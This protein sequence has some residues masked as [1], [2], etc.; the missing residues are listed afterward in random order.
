MLTGYLA[1]W[2]TGYAQ[3]SVTIPA[4]E[5]VVSE[6]GTISIDVGDLSGQNVTS[7]QF[8]IAY[9]SSLINFSGADNAGT[10]T[11]G[12]APIVNTSTPGE[13]TV[14]WA[15]ATPLSGSGTLVKLEAD[16]LQAGNA[17]L[18][19]QSFV[20]NEGT[21]ASST[22]NGTVTITTGGTPSVG[23]R[24]PASS[25]GELGGGAV[26][27]PITVGN[28]GGLNV[29]SYSFTVAYNQAVVGISNT[30]ANG[31]L[32][33]GGTIN[34]NTNQAGQITV[35]WSGGALSG[36]GTLIN[37]IVD[38]LAVGSSQLTFNEFQFNSG[39]PAANLTN[40]SFSVTANGGSVSV[41]ISQSLVG[42]V[43][44]SYMIPI[45]VGETTGK[46]VASFEMELDY[47]SSILRVDGIDQAGTLS[48]NTAAN[49]N[50][51]TPGKVTIAWA[52]TTNLSG[53]GTLINLQVTLLSLGTS[54]LAFSA[55]QFNEGA[56]P[57]VASDG[58]ITVRS[59]ATY[60]Q[61]VHNSS[62]AE[63]VDI[64][65]NDEKQIDALA[66]GVATAFLELDE[67]NLKL[68]V[69][70]DGASDNSTPITTTNVSLEDNRDYVAV[71]NGLFAGSGKQAIDLVVQES[72]QEASDANT[73][74][75]LVFQGSPDAPALNVYIVGDAPSYPRIKPLAETLGF[76]E[77][78]ISAEFEPGVYNFEITQSDG[79]RVGI[80]RADLSR[81]AGAAL[82][83]IIQGFVN[84]IVGQPP[85]TVAVY[86]PD[87]RA[88][89]LPTA[90]DNEQEQ[91][92]PSGFRIQGNYPNPFNPSTSIQFDL[93]EAARVTVDVYDLLGRQVMSVP[94]QQYY[95][96]QDQIAQL[97][98][99]ELASG[100]YVYRVT[101]EGQ[102]QRYV[103]SNTMMLLK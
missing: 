36:S 86:A 80:Y 1:A 85:F 16:Y 50:L 79:S 2:N 81:T 63:T 59:G 61:I 13:I 78:Y 66:Y 56:P 71:I 39:S 5:G 90:T 15:S 70:A 17:T 48:E 76:G 11:G 73:V 40:G 42:S 60:L 65:I 32:S 51:D 27:V 74:G 54:S 87:G 97:D 72:Q 28:L 12:T 52:S 100:T 10:L 24:L 67:P 23:V 64:Y 43:G 84:P 3:V 14:A 69:V 20:F 25:G 41:S 58:S 96:G 68:D 19:F 91:G 21:P 26:T 34:V 35:S 101:A 4:V 6:S 22:S 103:S 8:T 93:P 53:Q 57:A 62:D 49:I 33:E 77:S 38:P 47:N 92:L 55:F 9:N 83:F 94:P 37:L 7:F 88:I 44:A 45:T 29:T 99:S 30:S 102:R 95:A 75:L 89:F 82:L 31:A 18:T 98:A 46:G